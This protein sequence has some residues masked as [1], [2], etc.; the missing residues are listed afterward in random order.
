MKY[1]YAFININHTFIT[2]KM[3]L[4]KYRVENVDFLGK[5]KINTPIP[6][7][8]HIVIGLPISNKSYIMEIDI[9]LS[10]CERHFT[11]YKGIYECCF[12]CNDHD[13]IYDDN[14]YICQINTDDVL[15]NHSGCIKYPQD[16]VQ[17]CD[18]I[19][20]ISAYVFTNSVPKLKKIF[21]DDK[22]SLIVTDDGE[23][24]IYDDCYCAISYCKTDVFVHDIELVALSDF[25]YFKLS[26]RPENYADIE[27][28]IN[29]IVLP[30][31][32]M[33]QC[34]ELF[35]EN[36]SKSVILK[37][38]DKIHVEIPVYLKFLFGDQSAFFE[39]SK[40]NQSNCNK[41]YH[42]INAESLKIIIRWLLVLITRNEL[43]KI[44]LVPVGAGWKR[45]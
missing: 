38:I 37:C 35:L 45:M 16:I 29:K 18:I 10:R 43:P 39:I 14:I 11:I 4:K 36:P 2:N 17:K 23:K 24:F 15:W 9:P 32:Q 12:F 22:N 19:V 7:A 41:S 40:F 25:Q 20:V 21:I 6:K 28:L 1:N 30:L 27:R 13:P 26:S 5:Y 42:D 44:D 33:D 8:N 34:Y 31:E 3:Q